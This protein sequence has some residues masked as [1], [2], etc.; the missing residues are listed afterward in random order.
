MGEGTRDQTTENQYFIEFTA[1]ANLVGQDFSFYKE[2]LKLEK[3]DI[4]QWLKAI[5]ALP[6]DPGS[7]LICHMPITTIC[8]YSSMEF[9]DLFWL[10]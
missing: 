6:E 5:A 8:N 3:W 10:L 7:I 2:I 9:N 1:K 4:T